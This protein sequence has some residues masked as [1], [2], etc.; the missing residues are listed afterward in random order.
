MAPTG[1]A[2]R[3]VPD[4][5]HLKQK[6]V[7]SGGH[8]R[9]IDRWDSLLTG[10]VSI[11]GSILPTAAVCRPLEVSGLIDLPP[12][13]LYNLPLGGGPRSVEPVRRARVVGPRA[14]RSQ[15]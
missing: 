9:D 1:A 10:T 14:T 4:I 7:T 6:E 5:S 13:E 12:A 11:G 15:L 8:E 3:E 2:P